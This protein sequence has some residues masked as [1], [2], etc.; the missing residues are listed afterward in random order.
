MSLEREL[1]MLGA[2]L[3]WPVAPDA[4]GAVRERLEAAP[5]RARRRL[6][7]PLL[8]LAAAVLVAVAAALAVPQARTAIFRALGI[9]SVR[10]V[11]VDELPAASPRSDLAALGPV[12]TAAD[13]RAVF[14]H[15]LLEPDEDVLGAV[16][17]IR[18]RE[19][20]PMISYLWIER[21]QPRL[22][23]SQLPGS[24]SM[25][26]V[27]LVGPGASVD[28]MTIDGRRAVWIEGEAH[29]FGLVGDDGEEF[30]DAVAFE[31][32]RLAGNTLLVELAETTL[33]IEGELTRDQAI[34]VARAFIR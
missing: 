25:G 33:R 8:A 20:P 15:P 28:E 4:T 31:E 11:L 16:S 19:S 2:V 3:E 5:S 24:P 17:E 10:V 6:R 22:L 23:V 30:D 18:V 34:H 1:R 12:A 7:R 29:G 13:A 26:F 9:G 27:K 32:L 14:P 21:E